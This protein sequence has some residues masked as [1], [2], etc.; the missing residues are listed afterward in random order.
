MELNCGSS[1]LPRPF[2]SLARPAPCPCPTRLHRHQRTR[3]DARTAADVFSRET[4]LIR[5]DPRY[6]TYL[7]CG[8]LMRG[9]VA[10]I[11]NIN[12]NVAR[13]RPSLRMAHWNNEVRWCGGVCAAWPWAG[14][15][16]ALWGLMTG[17][18]QA[19]FT[20]SLLMM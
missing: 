20:A 18:R 11:S 14:V 1:S 5:A 6:G 9:A 10:N 8:L 4:Q 3:A 7:A 12:R 17:L 2:T 16:G 13:L 19:I 15:R